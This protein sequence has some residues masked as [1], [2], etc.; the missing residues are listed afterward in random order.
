MILKEWWSLP[1]DSS[2][3]K[4]PKANISRKGGSLS[5]GVFLLLLCVCVCMCVCMYVL[6]LLFV[7]PHPPEGH[8]NAK[9]GS[10]SSGVFLFVLCVCFVVVVVCLPSPSC[11]FWFA[12]TVHQPAELKVCTLTLCC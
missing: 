2:M 9:G 12:L 11:P 3:W 8:G 4:H 1:R 7:F 10:L 5:S 6:L